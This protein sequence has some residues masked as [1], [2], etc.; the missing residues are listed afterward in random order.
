MFKQNVT[1]DELAAAMSQSQLIKEA[2]D[3]SDADNIGKALEYLNEA[4]SL[5]NDIDMPKAAEVTS[6]IILKVALILKVAQER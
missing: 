5:F 1:A 3:R 2:E 4:V 6:R